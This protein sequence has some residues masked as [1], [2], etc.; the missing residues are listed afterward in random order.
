MAFDY[1][2]RDKLLK[3]T[4][5]EQPSGPGMREHQTS[6]RM[7]QCWKN[8]SSSGEVTKIPDIGLSF[9]SSDLVDLV[10]LVIN[11]VSTIFSSVHVHSNDRNPGAIQVFA[12]TWKASVNL[13]ESF[14]G[15]QFLDEK[16]R[17][18]K[19][20]LFCWQFW[21]VLST[22]NGAWKEDNWLILYLDW[23]P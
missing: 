2:G 11:M 17:C 5:G 1:P 8:Y 15:R 6:C 13:K 10:D 20:F 3:V 4:G 22:S 21:W 9:F 19:G 18:I 23:Y 14:C 16:S 7:R 12:W